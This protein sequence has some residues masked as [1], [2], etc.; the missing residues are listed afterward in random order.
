[1]DFGMYTP[2]SRLVQVRPELEHMAAYQPG[3]SLEAFS[4]RTG[5]PINQLIKLNSNESPYAPPPE[6]LRALSGYPYY[7]NYPDTDSHALREAL[8]GYTGIESR[9][10]AVHH[11]S[12]E[13]I[14]LLWHLFL[15]VGDNIIAC[16]PTYS[17]YASITTF[18]G[19]SMLEIPRNEDYEI[20]VAAILAALT[21]QTKLIV[22]CSPNNPT[23]NVVPLKDILTLLDT[24]R[25]VVLDEAYIEFSNQPKG[26]AHLVPHYDNLV[27]TRTFSKWAGL[28]GLRI[29]YALLPEWIYNY[30]RRAQCPFEVNV[31]GH[32]AAI[33]TLR[34]LD[35]T[36]A[37]VRRIIEERAR[38]FRLLVSQSYLHPF[39]SQGNYILAR[40]NEEQVKMEQIREAVESHGIMLRYFRFSNLQNYIRVT[41]G[42]PEHTD[43]L[44]IALM[45]LDSR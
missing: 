21:P 43:K 10:I 19:A 18:C 2:S 12:M 42:R 6:V 39:P 4:N 1:M 33:E 38:L 45:G 25:I 9:F 34:H 30:M 5:V 24:G 14:N 20:D 28:A 26:L 15:S 13:L 22:L 3:E 29:G 32:L 23:G 7:N 16:P 27:I 11:G 40:V 36:L 17:L 35:Y 44:A 41:V 37:N 8:A 31:A